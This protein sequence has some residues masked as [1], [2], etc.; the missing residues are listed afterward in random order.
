MPSAFLWPVLVPCALRAPAPVNLGVRPPQS[1]SDELMLQ[2]RC[3]TLTKSSILISQLRFKLSRSLISTAL[4]SFVAL[5]GCGGGGGDTTPVTPNGQSSSAYSE[6]TPLTRYTGPKN[7]FQRVA[8]TMPADGVVNFSLIGV[9]VRIFDA[10]MRFIEESSYT[11]D[12][13]Y[14][15]NL[16]AGKYIV[17]FEYWSSNTRDAVIYSPALLTGCGNTQQPSPR[18][19]GVMRYQRST[20]TT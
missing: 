14:L 10:S 18:P 20:S 17:E 16:S 1:S 19:S 15:A 7:T 2:F 8:L 9:R 6:L 3:N 4:F 5:T 11:P 12:T 13:T